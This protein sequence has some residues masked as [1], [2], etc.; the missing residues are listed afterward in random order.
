M[1]CPGGPAKATWPVISRQAGAAG[2]ARRS[3]N[4]PA[5]AAFPRLASDSVRT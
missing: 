2:C 3:R 5:T 4:H 1:S